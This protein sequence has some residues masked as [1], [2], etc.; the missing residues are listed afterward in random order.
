ME[1]A[2]WAVYVLQYDIIFELAFS[3]SGIFL[4]DPIGCSQKNFLTSF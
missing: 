1:G 3:Y 2:I 4:H